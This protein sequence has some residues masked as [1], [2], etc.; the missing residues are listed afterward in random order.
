MSKQRGE[1]DLYFDYV[2]YFWSLGT[3]TNKEVDF[4]ALNKLC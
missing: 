3:M 1:N 2:V 4:V